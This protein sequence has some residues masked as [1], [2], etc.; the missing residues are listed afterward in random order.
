M[1]DDVTKKFY[2]GYDIHIFYS[3]S[4]MDYSFEIWDKNKNLVLESKR[5]YDSVGD[6]HIRAC[7]RINDELP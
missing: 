2:C 1:N 5:P 4:Y 7:T 6:A 3:H